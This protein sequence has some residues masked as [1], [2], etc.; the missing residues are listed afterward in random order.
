[1]ADLSVIGRACHTSKKL[2]LEEDG[3]GRYWVGGMGGR[4]ICLCFLRLS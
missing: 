2:T 3:E 4:G 1:M